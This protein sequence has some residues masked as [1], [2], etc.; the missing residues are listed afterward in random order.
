[1]TGSECG[2]FQISSGLFGQDL[3]AHPQSPPD[4]PVS[5]SLDLTS[6]C[7]LK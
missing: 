7:N 6:S 1:M 3:L 5:A 2:D 4:F